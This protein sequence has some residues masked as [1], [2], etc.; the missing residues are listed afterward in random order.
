MNPTIL[1]A[2]IGNI[3]LGDDAFGVEV[4]QRLA[5]RNLPEHVRVMDCGIRSYDLAYALM[6]P[7]EL[8]I[9]VDAVPRG[10]APGTLY[11]IEPELPTTSAAAFNLDAHSMNPVSV[12]QLVSALQPRAAEN[13]QRGDPAMDG[14]VGRMLIVGCEPEKIDMDE[15]G[16]MG[17]SKPVQAAVEEAVRLIEKL[18]QENAAS[19]AA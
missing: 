7:W 6:E 13:G 3:F 2:G 14:K 8:A 12:L 10:A 1:I 4:V 9:L 15:A 17:L 19:A 5:R 16:S 18:I 11:T